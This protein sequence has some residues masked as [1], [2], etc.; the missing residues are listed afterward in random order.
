MP[1][2]KLEQLDGDISGIIRGRD[3]N[4]F[5]NLDFKTLFHKEHKVEE[6]LFVRN[7]KL[8]IR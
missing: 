5:C 1:L 6:N 7:T 2:N 3:S 8:G 4:P